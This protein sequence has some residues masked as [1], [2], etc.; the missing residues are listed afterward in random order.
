MNLIFFYM[1]LCHDRESLS[2]LLKVYKYVLVG[3]ANRRYS[4]FKADP[5]ISARFSAENSDYWNSGWSRGH[6]A[7]AGNNKFNQVT[8]NVTFSQKLL[9]L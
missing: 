1:G 5:H 8:N 7:P 4:K 6:M 3:G 2:L 9:L